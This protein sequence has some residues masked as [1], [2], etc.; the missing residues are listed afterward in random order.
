MGQKIVAFLVTLYVMLAGHPGHV[1]RIESTAMMP[2]YFEGQF[3]TVVE[4]NP[5]DLRRGEG[6]VFK[7]PDNPKES[8]F[9]RII[10]LPGDVFEIRGSGVWINDEILEENYDLIPTDESY[11]FGPITVGKDEF[12]V[13]GDNRPNSKDSRVIGAISFDLVE[14]KAQITWWENM[15]NGTFT[16]Q[17]Q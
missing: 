8:F 9:K 17:G 14:G 15:L 5:S 12:F 7:N 4:A 1:Y 11:H 6:I 16:K 10:G 2:N 13:M 3:V